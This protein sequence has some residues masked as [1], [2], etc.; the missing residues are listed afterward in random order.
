MNCDREVEN[1]I[2][3]KTACSESLPYLV[4]DQRLG[5]SFLIVSYH[6]SGLV[7]DL[8]FSIEQFVRRY[9]YEI[10]VCD[11]SCD[12]EERKALEQ[13]SRRAVRTFFPDRNIGFVAANNFL[14]TKAN[15]RLLALVNP[16][17][18]LIDCSIERLF[19]FVMQE[20]EVGIAGPQLI[21]EDGS[22]QV[23][24]YKFPTLWGLLKE[25]VL[26]ARKHP[27]AYGDQGN[28][29]EC[30]V[31]KGA[32]IVIRRDLAR[33]VGLF[34]DDLTM[35]S[36]E[37]DLC[38]RLSRK[39]YRRIFFP[40]ARIVH[41][42]EKSTRRR[43]FTEYSLY[44]YHRSRLV[45]FRKHHGCCYYGLVKAILVLSLAEKTVLFFLVGKTTSSRVHLSVLRQ[46]LFT[47]LLSQS[48]SPVSCSS[49]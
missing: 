21:N 48:R 9:D 12:A 20:R 42:G 8:V 28:V 39:G 29:C 37:V 24:H 6:T 41:Y 49:S 15:H 10:L 27:Y 46:L 31:V 22:I 45:Y 44:H 1:E 43:E 32:C 33:F 3:F 2:Q 19:D 13:L 23:G 25:H 17:S 14:L 35:Y 5:V 18:K 16:D 40:L 7:R 36:E 34:D 4:E 38:K 30:D 26:L 11:N 47:P